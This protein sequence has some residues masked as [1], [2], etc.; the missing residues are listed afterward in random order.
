MKKIKKRCWACG[1]LH[2]IQRGKNKVA[3]GVLNAGTAI[4][5]FRNDAVTMF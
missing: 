4:F 1:S 3:N 5:I 2:V